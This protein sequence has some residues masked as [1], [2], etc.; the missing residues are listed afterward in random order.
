MIKLIDITELSYIHNHNAVD[1]MAWGQVCM[2]KLIDITELSY[3]HNNNAVG[4][5]AWGQGDRRTPSLSD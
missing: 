5:M 2:I 4:R 3:I 1:R